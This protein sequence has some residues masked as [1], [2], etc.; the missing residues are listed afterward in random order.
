M[1]KIKAALLL[2]LVLPFSAQASW[3]GQSDKQKHIVL[4]GLIYG[5]SYAITNDSKSALM[6]TLGIGMAHELAKS[7]GVDRGDVA[8]DV[9]GAAAALTIV[10]I[11]KSF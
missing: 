9:A 8:A 3:L 1:R 4:S 10:K 6:L 7:S 5:S 11:S 2:V